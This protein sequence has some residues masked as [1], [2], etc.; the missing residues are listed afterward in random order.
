MGGNIGDWVG[1]QF[2]SEIS[3]VSGSVTLQGV[4]ADAH[5]A[6]LSGYLAEGCSSNGA[7]SM[8]DNVTAYNAQYPD[9]ETVVSG[10]R[11]LF[12]TPSPF[13]KKVHDN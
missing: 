5:A 2:F 12:P 4:D 13:V 6:D 8:A 7:S 10:W 11:Y 9:S 1:P 3:G